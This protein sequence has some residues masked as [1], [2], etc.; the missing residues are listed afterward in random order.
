MR[1]RFALVVVVMIVVSYALITAGTVAYAQEAC[2]EWYHDENGSPWTNPNWPE[3]L[4]D[5]STTTT[6]S[7]PP[8]TD[9]PPPTTKPPIAATT[10]THPSNHDIDDYND[11]APPLVDTDQDGVPDDV[12]VLIGG[13]PGES[14]TDG[15][16]EPDGV[17]VG[18]ELN[19]VMPVY[20]DDLD[21]F[22]PAA[23]LDTD[24]DTKPDIIESDVDDVG[25]DG[26]VDELDPDDNT[27]PTTTSTTATTTVS[28]TSTPVTTPTT[29]ADA[30][31][32]VTAGGDTGN[33]SDDDSGSAGLLPIA[34]FG[35][36]TI[37]GVGGAMWLIATRRRRNNEETQSG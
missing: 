34:V 8:T 14:D 6:T 12:E 13:D 29:P 23:V 19:T 3:C 17:E 35:A 21:G 22:D 9:P 24:G 10:T 31:A 15:D 20:P 1:K 11:S 32:T 28:T 5:S 16:G 26:I 2:E 30:T 37:G 25:G 33:G 4:E 7:P 27:P 36:V 18:D